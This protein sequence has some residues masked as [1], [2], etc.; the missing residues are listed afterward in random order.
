MIENIRAHLKMVSDIINRLPYQ[1]MFFKVFNLVLFIVF[2]GGF[3]VLPTYIKCIL[4]V[5]MFYCWGL[6][7]FYL[8]MERTY[9]KVYDRIRP[10]DNTNFNMYIT[11]KSVTWKNAL[12]SKSVL[13]FYLP[14][15]I[16]SILGVV[17]YG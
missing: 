4:I 14:M 15:I 5:P 1:A 17:L 6:D 3:T 16:S 9:R 10:C 2:C 13:W 12:L 7:A 8:K 11:D